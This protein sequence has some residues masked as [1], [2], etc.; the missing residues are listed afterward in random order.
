MGCMHSGND[1]FSSRCCYKWSSTTATASWPT[2]H[3]LKIKVNFLIVN[4]SF[5]FWKLL[6]GSYS[7]RS[8][9]V[10]Q[11]SLQRQIC[12]IVKSHKNTISNAH[13]RVAQLGVR[14]RA[15]G[16]PNHL[17]SEELQLLANSYLSLDRPQSLSPLSTFN[18]E[19][20]E[21]KLNWLLYPL[22]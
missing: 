6:Q 4:W 1:D 20:L 22:L 2:S 7:C 12:E 10:S 9:L 3:P 16:V 18:T 11:V 8:F 14:L 5:D 13:L 17:K 15:K 21:V 19:N